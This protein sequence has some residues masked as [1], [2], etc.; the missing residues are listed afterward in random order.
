MARARTSSATGA[1]AARHPTAQALV[2]AAIA[3]IEEHGEGLVRIGDIL[4]RSGVSSGSL[5]HHFGGKEALLQEATVERYVRAISY[6]LGRVTESIS[7]VQ[8]KADVIAFLTD[9][10]QRLDAP[11]LVEQRRQRI[12]ALGSA[13]RQ[14]EVL[15][16]IG[17]RQAELFEASGAMVDK[18]LKERGL[19]NPD[20][21]SRAFAAW[22]FALLLDRFILDIDPEEGADEDWT[23]LSRLALIAILD[24]RDPAS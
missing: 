10:L 19:I 7:K 2:E 4:E 21:N 8:T 1:S 17:R 11:E 13:A 24:P 3:E 9:E 18:V 20:L 12:S 23:E 14:P 16:E 15:A 22:F 5:Y 6:G